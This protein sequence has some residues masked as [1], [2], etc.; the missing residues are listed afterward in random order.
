MSHGQGKPQNGLGNV[1]E[2]CEGSW[3]DSLNVTMNR[4]PCVTMVGWVDVQDS[5]QGEFAV[6][7]QSTYLV[8]YVHNDP[9]CHCWAY[10]TDLNGSCFSY[11]LLGGYFSMWLYFTPGDYFSV[12]GIVK[13][14]IVAISN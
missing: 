11:F 4:D 1:R 10:V 9:I 3:L 5:D 6:S 13:R 14:F 8:N 2:F 7:V 12:K